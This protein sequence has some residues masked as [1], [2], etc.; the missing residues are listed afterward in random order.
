MILSILKITQLFRKAHLI[1]EVLIAMHQEG[2]MESIGDC[3][4]YRCSSTTVDELNSK[5]KNM[6]EQLKVW[7]ERV[8]NARSRYYPLNSFTNK[9]LCQ[10]RREL[11]AFLSPCASDSIALTCEVKFLLSALLPCASDSDIIKALRESR[12]QLLSSPTTAVGSP[13]V[14]RSLIT[15][16]SSKQ[17]ASASAKITGEALEITDLV[18]SS[19]LSLHE[20]DNYM[21]LTESEKTEPMLTLLAVLKSSDE[22]NYELP[23]ALE[24]FEFLQLQVMNSKLT[25]SDI[26]KQINE[27]LSQRSPKLCLKK[28]AHV[29]ATSD[30]RI[31]STVEPSE[32]RPST[33]SSRSSIVDLSLQWYI[34]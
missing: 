26:N 10:L 20:Q 7:T 5:A 4:C 9:Q 31:S 17:A 15:S 11:C 18:K 6:D 29:L 25:I 14:S 13:R 21:N 28:E 33:M 2:Y 19:V 22:G 16:D 30:E 23:D 12:Q 34:A 8:E 27:Y 1:A 3:Y 24:K 32:K